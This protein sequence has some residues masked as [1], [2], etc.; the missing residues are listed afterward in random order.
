MFSR[1]RRNR[2]RSPS[3]RSNT[4]P[5]AGSSAKASALLGPP[6]PDRQPQPFALPPKM[7]AQALLK[8]PTSSMP[9]T[10]ISRSRR[11]RKG[12]SPRRTASQ[13][14]SMQ[15]RTM[16]TPLANALSTLDPFGSFDQKS[17]REQL[18][19]SW[20][21]VTD[22]IGR[23]YGYPGSPTD[24]SVRAGPPGLA[25]SSPVINATQ[26]LDSELTGSSSLPTLPSADPTSHLKTCESDISVLHPLPSMDDPSCHQGHTVLYRKR[27]VQ[28]EE[29]HD[30]SA[31]RLCSPDHSVMGQQPSSRGV[32]H[33][34]PAPGSS[35]LPAQH[36]TQ[37]VPSAD[38][39]IPQNSMPVAGH[40]RLKRS[41]G[42]SAQQ[43][44]QVHLSQVPTASCSVAVK[45]L[46]AQTEAMISSASRC[47]PVKTAHT[48]SAE[49]F[50]THGFPD[51][52][53]AGSTD[54]KSK[55]CI[56]NAGDV[57]SLNLPPL[58]NL[59]A[60]SDSLAPA[61]TAVISV[62]EGNVGS[63]GSHE[64]ESSSAHHSTLPVVAALM[65]HAKDAQTSPTSRKAGPLHIKDHALLQASLGAKQQSPVGLAN[66]ADL[67]ASPGFQQEPRPRPHGASSASP[68]G[69]METL[70]NTAWP[71]A[72]AGLR[73]GPGGT[74]VAALKATSTLC[75]EPKGWQEERRVLMC[76]LRATLADA[77][78][79]RHQANSLRQDVG[80]LSPA[81]H[82][83]LYTCI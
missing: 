31:G 74:A 39:L 44:E 28:P 72:A 51:G 69:I 47:S 73:G 41:Q 24:A 42:A 79:Q 33:Q 14:P 49:A 68:S 58:P 52:R 13:P 25:T 77:N 34:F 2:L 57:L 16:R 10:S 12:S 7:Q 61:A 19:R 8:L 9:H 20:S 65:G 30:K 83:G 66:H 1:L 48:L 76:A 21:R 11:H 5:A 59:A 78:A 53:A 26:S 70:R 35:S 54:A 3:S 4:A 27:P 82:A 60:H 37:P 32:K 80:P 15:S 67:Q 18:E 40:P 64:A 45:G 6:S 46:S 38:N 17:T 22:S 29:H 56:Q 55:L 71:S 36:S 62:T 50:R 63:T 23:A 75:P 81:G 43:Q